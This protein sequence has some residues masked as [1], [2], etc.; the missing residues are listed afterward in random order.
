M[1]DSKQLNSLKNLL[2]K[3]G[4]LNPDELSEFKNNPILLID[5]GYECVEQ[6][7]YEQAYE[8]FKMGMSMDNSDP[9][10]LNGLG[11][12]LCEMGKF[13]ESKTVLLQA[14]QSTPEDAITLANIAG[15]CWEMESY[16]EAIYYYHQALKNDSDIE[17][18]YFN[19]INLYME[20]DMLHIAYITALD[21]VKAF[22]QS[23]DASDL[24][25]DILINMALCNL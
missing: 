9:D 24:L 13:D 19:L 1:N 11:I 7:K 5:I 3:E 23:K 6:G 8:L 15:V 14:L 17:E 25:N 22:P 2:L 21:F 10:I 4:L 20:N 18:I 12:T 16:D